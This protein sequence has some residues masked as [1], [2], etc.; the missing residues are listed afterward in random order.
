MMNAED[1]A[2]NSDKS[3]RAMQMAR[4]IIQNEWLATGVIR[5]ELEQDNQLECLL[6]KLLKA[7]RPLNDILAEWE[8]KTPSEILSEYVVTSA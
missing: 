5:E 8:H 4:E 1:G 2:N 3:Q 7:G 6:G